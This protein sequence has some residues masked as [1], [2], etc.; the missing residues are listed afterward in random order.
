MVV[1]G[2]IALQQIHECAQL[3]PRDVGPATAFFHGAQQRKQGTAVGRQIVAK[4]AVLQGAVQL[5]QL[6]QQGKQGRGLAI[7]FGR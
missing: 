7:Q 2:S 3:Q 1:I 4:G 5:L 6:S